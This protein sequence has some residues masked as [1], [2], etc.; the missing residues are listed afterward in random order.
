MRTLI[1][2]INV[3]TYKESQDLLVTTKESQSLGRIAFNGP[4]KV[5]VH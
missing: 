2:V 4:N 1:E 3:F 5:V